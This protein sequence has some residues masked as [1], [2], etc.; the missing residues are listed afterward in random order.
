MSK[1]IGWI[2]TFELIEFEDA[3]WIEISPYKTDTF[4]T[5]LY[6]HPMRELTDEE[7]MEVLIEEG[8]YVN[9]K[10]GSFAAYQADADLH[11]FA[12]AILKKVSERA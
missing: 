3:F 8:I 9:L 1:P 10:G 12:R 5:P 2:D 11:K 6:T 7:I 4:K